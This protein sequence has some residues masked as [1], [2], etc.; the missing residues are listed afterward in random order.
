MNQTF[1]I[2]RFETAR[3]NQ[4]EDVL[5]HTEIL[6]IAEPKDKVIRWSAL[7]MPE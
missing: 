7:K 5:H 3:E 6:T 4:K 1:G 2:D